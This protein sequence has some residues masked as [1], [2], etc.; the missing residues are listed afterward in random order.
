MKIARLSMPGHADQ[1]ADWRLRAITGYVGRQKGR[2]PLTETARIFER[3]G[4]TLVR[5]VRRLEEGMAVDA[6]LRDLVESV[7]ARIED[8]TLQT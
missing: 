4:T 2:I 1:S 7:R 6:E 8:A 5:D 3:H